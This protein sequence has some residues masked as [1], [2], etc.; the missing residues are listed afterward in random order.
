MNGV[1]V[2]P[3]IRS[4]NNYNGNG[5]ENV[6]NIHVC[7]VLSISA[8]LLLVYAVQLDRGILQRDSFEWHGSEVKIKNE[9]F[10]VVGSR[11]R[12]NLKFAVFSFLSFLLLLLL[13]IYFFFCVVILKNTSRKCT[14]ML[15]ACAA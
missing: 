8:L 12:Q 1:D 4:L 2:W 7:S 6:P 10:T 14:K 11:F 15:V 5:M 3:G 13:F 9:R